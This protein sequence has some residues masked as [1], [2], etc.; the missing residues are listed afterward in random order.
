MFDA[1]TR[2]S[3]RRRWSSVVLIGSF[4]VH[5]AAA[6][7]VMVWS[8]WKIE[9]LVPERMPVSIVWAGTDQPQV[10]AA[11]PEAKPAPAKKNEPKREPRDTVQPTKAPPVEVLPDSTGG[12][13]E[14]TTPAI[15]GGGSSTGG[16]PC[17]GPCTGEVAQMVAT[18]VCGD[19]QRA[20]GERC[21]DGNTVDGDGCSRQ[22]Q[23]EPPRRREV[24]T[25]ES[26]RVSGE[27]RILPPASVQS[28]M[29]RGGSA[30]VDALF[31]VC[32]DA[33]GRVTEVTQRKS[34]GFAEYDARLASGV[35]GWRYRPHSVDG[36][37]VPVCGSVRFVYVQR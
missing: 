31:R 28:Q 20:D 19:G 18:P 34:T 9:L 24:Q 33:A 11:E 37:A 32:L 1:L 23:L 17:E 26:L 36:A 6:L 29:Q 15:G 35:R 5:A 27:A 22:C 25:V 4:G 30:R 12:G 13:G 14:T 3:P 16:P 21:D 8:M 10:P 7:A 2:R